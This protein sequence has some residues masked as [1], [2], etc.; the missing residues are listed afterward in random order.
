LAQAVFAQ[1]VW[2]DQLLLS[3]PVP[4]MAP[5][6]KLTSV[7]GA[8]KSALATLV[9]KKR[10]AAAVRECGDDETTM[11]VAKKPAA[12]VAHEEESGKDVMKKPSAASRDV[13]GD[14]EEGDEKEAFESPEQEA[15][16][17]VKSV[18]QQQRLINKL[19]AENDKYL[20]R[21]K[22]NKSLL[23]KAE[24]EMEGM[25]AE[26]QKKTRK[27]GD[28]MR[29]KIRKKMAGKSNRA[30]D[31]AERLTAKLK[32]VRKRYNKILKSAKTV[33]GKAGDVEIVYKRAQ[34][35]YDDAKKECARLKKQGEEVPDE[36]EK[37]LS[38]SGAF[39][40]PGLRAALAR[41]AAKQQLAKARA[42]WEKAAAPSSAKEERLKALKDNIKEIQQQQES[43]EAEIK[44]AKKL[45]RKGK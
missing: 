1:A 36:G 45:P 15:R 30:K 18:S 44:A 19:S 3:S 10:P 35:A 43:A 11:K 24:K 25:K 2:L 6:R 13:H 40:P 38:A 22:N 12:A 28:K 26:A 31:K 16:A 5:R 20:E 9:M 39:K 4:E 17:A 33:Q 8:S 21:V 14:G 7:S 34:K 42:A 23:R 41:D 27:L 29:S 37:D 32:A